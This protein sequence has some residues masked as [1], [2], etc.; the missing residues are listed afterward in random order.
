MQLASCLS[1]CPLCMGLH[2][3]MTLLAEVI[4]FAF[5]QPETT[6]RQKKAG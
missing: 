6:E 3:E 4:E 2:I 5:L 1:C